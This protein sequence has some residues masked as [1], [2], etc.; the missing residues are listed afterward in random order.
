MSASPCESVS[1]GV[2]KMTPPLSPPALDC[3]RIE[4]EGPAITPAKSSRDWMEATSQH[5]AYRCTPMTI[6]NASGWELC[7]PFSFDAVWDGSDA[8]EAITILTRA[9]GDKVGKLIASHFGYGILTFHT[10]WLFRTPPGWALWARGTP[11]LSKDGIAPLEGLVETDWLPFTFTMNWRF[12]RPGRVRFEKGE[13][14][15]FMTL[16]PHGTLDA[17]QPVLHEI[18]DDP[19]LAADYERWR[20]SRADFNARLR[21]KDDA[22]IREGWQRGYIRASQADERSDFHVTKRRLKVPK[23]A[24]RLR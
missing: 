9:G 12:A 14:F 18:T 1:E 15:C 22:A 7:C 10:G 3:F 8:I 5:F 20:D 19:A 2:V 11:N 6:A 16:A 13:P 23:P 17:I 4:P 21:G 24:S